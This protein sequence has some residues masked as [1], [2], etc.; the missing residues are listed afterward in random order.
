MRK[1]SSN[2]YAQ[3][4]RFWSSLTYIN[5]RP[6]SHLYIRSVIKC[7]RLQPSPSVQ[8][9]N[10]NLSSLDF[11]LKVIIEP[12]NLQISPTNCSDSKLLKP[13]QNLCT[14]TKLHTAAIMGK[15]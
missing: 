11:L 13:L 14:P 6:T 5:Y 2:N 8:Q 9:S 3:G 4:V 15:L 10:I 7:A 1:V 12:T